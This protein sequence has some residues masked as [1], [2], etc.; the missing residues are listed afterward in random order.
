MHDDVIDSSSDATPLENTAVTSRSSP[1]L[2][3]HRTRFIA[4]RAKGLFQSHFCPPAIFPTVRTGPSGA[5][6]LT[7]DMKK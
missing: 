5:H 4:R 3:C 7:V 1:R 2:E 6:E